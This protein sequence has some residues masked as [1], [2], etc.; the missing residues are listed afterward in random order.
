MWADTQDQ[1]LRG[2][3]SAK[4]LSQAKDYENTSCVRHMQTT[5]LITH[6]ESL[7]HNTHNPT[8]DL[9]LA[10]Q[11]RQR[12]SLKDRYN[13]ETEQIRKQT[14]TEYWVHLGSKASASDNYYHGIPSPRIQWRRLLYEPIYPRIQRGPNPSNA[15]GTHRGALSCCSTMRFLVP[16]ICN[17]M[18]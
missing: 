2:R 8:T 9:D 11:L 3:I 15:L 6:Q 7:L 13:P 12:Q 16:R 1:N 18:R 14:D 4:L 10:Q 17:E 5:T